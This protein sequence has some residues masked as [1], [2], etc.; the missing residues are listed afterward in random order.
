MDFIV[1]VD[2]EADNQWEHGI[3]VSCDNVAYWEP[4]QRLCRAHDVVPTY[5]ITSEIA[6][7]PSGTAMLAK[8]VD[9]GHAEVGAHLHPWTTPP[10]VDL[11]GLRFNDVQHVFAS[12]LPEDLLRAKLRTLTAQISENVGVRP[13]SYRA[14]RFGMNSTTSRVLVE[15]GYLVDSSVT[16]LVSWSRDSGTS[17]MRGSPDFRHHTAA[18]FLIEGSGGSGL[19]ELPVTV[20]LSSRLVRR[21]SLLTGPYLSRSAR[22]ARRVL[23]GGIIRPEP[24]WLRPFPHAR[25]ADLR[26]AWRAAEEDGLSTAVMMLHSS[27]LMPGASP[28]RPTRRTVTGLLAML[29]EFFRFV[30]LV[31]GAPVSMT[32]GARRA[33][34]TSALEPRPL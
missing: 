11:D 19:V 22:V 8:W 3:P 1:S 34:R 26:R 30:A 25:T 12:A 33:R 31:G 18:P 17:S 24:V 15:L 14:G 21:H 2:T 16:P 9:E 23:H 4:F 6:E 32:E 20:V 13:R 10:F 7:S 5:L 29:D 28:Y 27:E